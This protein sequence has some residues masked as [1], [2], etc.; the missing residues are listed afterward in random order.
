VENFADYGKLSG[1]KLEE[2]QA[3]ARIDV[4]D[5]KRNPMDFCLWKAA[6]PGEI[7]WKSPWG[8][9]RPGWHIECSAMISQH[10]GDTLDI[11]GGGNDLIF[12]HH[13]NEI[14]QSESVTGKPLA[15]YWM[16]NGML[17]V[18]GDKMSKSTGNFFT[19]RDV[20]NSYT[21]QEVRFFFLNTHYRGPLN[22]NEDA[23]NESSASLRRLQHTYSELKE[24]ID[25]ATGSYDADDLVKNARSNF[26]EHMDDDLNSRGAISILFEIS[27]EVNKL[28]SHEMLSKKG[29]KSTITFLEEVDQLLGVL[30][31]MEQSSDLMDGVME[32]IISVRA[33]LRKRKLY[34]LA[35]KIRDELK[36]K[37]IVL[38]DTTEGIRWRQE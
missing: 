33:E 8:E 14:L 37:G 2:M 18:S 24:Y 28:M 25:T 26:M 3:G 10:M 11:H 15:R 22:Y 30:P 6:K 38:E 20:M 32:V 35:D 7:S 9:G 31:T 5:I 16:H 4:D 19:V 34:D 17:Q 21:T 1:N 12:P 27:R 29:A 13:E 23:L 36:E